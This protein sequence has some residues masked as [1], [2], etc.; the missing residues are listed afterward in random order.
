MVVPVMNMR[1]EASYRRTVAAFK[2]PTLTLLHGKFAPFVVA[3][4]SSVFT[5]DRPTAPVTDV[6]LEVG[7]TARE[8]RQAGYENLPS[9]NGR[10]ICRYW[11]RVG[12][13]VPQIEVGTEVYR[14][15]AQA[16]FALEIAGRVEG[17]RNKVSGS[18]VRTLL[19]SVES[20]AQNTET[21]PA[22]RIDA[23]TAE[24][25][26]LNERIEALERGE[27]ELPADEELLEEA[28]NVLHLSR[29]L[30]ADFA[31]V[32]ES[33]N[34]MQ[35]DVVSDLRRDVRPTGE[36]LREYLHRGQH[37][38]NSTPE[39]RAFAG[40]LRLI[41][42]PGQIDDL[43]DQL[44]ALMNH[45]FA[46]R[47]SVGERV[48]LVAVAKR[49]EQG[50]QEVLTAQR[51]ASHVITA[52]VRTHDPARDR[53]IDDLLRQA[54]AGMQ[55]RMRAPHEGDKVEPVRHFPRANVGHLRQSLDS[56]H[57]HSRP[58]PLTDDGDSAE[59]IDADTRAWGGPQYVELEEY[60]AGLGAGFDV[61]EAFASASDALRRPVDLVGLLEIANR[62]GLV[63]GEKVSVVETTRPDGTTRRFAFGEVRA[64]APEIPDD[65][66]GTATKKEQI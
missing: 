9:G 57:A 44:Y 7:D 33:I 56:L 41:G 27:L 2:S 32:S 62:N 25:D 50:V 52:Q 43:T 39:G 63:E 61:A 10:E 21:D 46:R 17:G 30:P 53:E 65:I 28:E 24:R 42:D 20:L 47:L 49:I 51:R 40:A 5:A 8:L 19:D 36:V 6:H 11:V 58:E 14:L 54:M 15:S 29:E 38:M 45:P 4:L 12:W 59:F 66:D 34:A 3:A 16:V 18:R 1:A 64:G 23:L 55:T 22:R 60:V 35:R 26:A 37:V 48:E 13:L 31:R